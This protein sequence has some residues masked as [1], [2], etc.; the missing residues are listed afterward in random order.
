MPTTLRM[1]TK[2]PACR[3]NEISFKTRCSVEPNGRSR[4]LLAQRTAAQ[5]VTQNAPAA[6]RVPSRPAAVADKEFSR[7]LVNGV[8]RDRDG[9]SHVTRRECKRLQ[10]L[11]AAHRDRIDVF[12]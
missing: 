1:P 5:M 4:G 11:R 6:R 9:R 2:R 7:A 3:S 10:R 8:G 12:G